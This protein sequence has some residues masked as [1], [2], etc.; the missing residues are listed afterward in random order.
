MKK[1]LRRVCLKNCGTGFL[2]FSLKCLISRKRMRKFADKLQNTEIE[3]KYLVSGDFP[4]QGG[5]SRRITQGYLCDDP[6]RTVRVRISGDKGFITVK[7]TGSS[8]GLS[9]FEWEKEISAADA[10]TRYEVP[11][12]GHVFE[13]DV[14]H[15][16]NDGLV[17]A[18]AE[19][20]SV[21]ENVELPEWIG[22][23]VTGDVRYYNSYLSAH[24]FSSWGV[25]EDVTGR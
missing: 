8:D 20:G 22:R 10:Q 25:G 23:E 18:E 24:P 13:V 17:L 11:Y 16:E 3:R 7:G 21:D 19:L 5:V 1:K 15:G 14:F 6:A 9:R 12:R 2:R 4:L